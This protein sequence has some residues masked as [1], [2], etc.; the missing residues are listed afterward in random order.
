[1][2][3]IFKNTKHA[4]DV[5]KEVQRRRKS[6]RMYLKEQIT[7]EKQSQDILRGINNICGSL[8]Q[9][10]D[11]KDITFYVSDE[12]LNTVLTLLAMDS[13]LYKYNVEGNMLRI[14]AQVAQ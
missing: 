11:V 14:Y 8:F 13:L 12:Q 7:K 3:D 4:L 9:T 6:R 5:R 2:G 1:M 10:T